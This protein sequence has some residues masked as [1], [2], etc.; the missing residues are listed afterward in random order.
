VSRERHTAARL[1]GDGFTFVLYDADRDGSAHRPS[2]IPR[3][4]NRIDGHELHVTGSAGQRFPADGPDIETML[5]NADMA[6]Y[7]AKAVSANSA[8]LPPP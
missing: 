5:R 7:K 3:R 8:V 2:S 4:A 6:M 1:G